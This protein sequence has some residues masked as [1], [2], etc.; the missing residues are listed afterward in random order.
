MD[1][2]ENNWHAR[3]PR[4]QPAQYARLGDVRVH[5]GEALAPA[6]AVDFPEGS[7]VFQ[8]MDSALQ[9][10]DQRDMYISIN[11]GQQRATRLRTQPGI[12]T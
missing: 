4:R 1:R 12:I 11:R 9:V 8:R 5:D 2:M 3:Q 6:E 10:R 7:E